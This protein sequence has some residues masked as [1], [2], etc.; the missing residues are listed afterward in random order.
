MD[1]V[2]FSYA[3]ALP[4]LA[5]VSLRLVPGWHGVVGANGAG[6]STLARLALREQA[7]NSGRVTYLPRELS[8]AIAEQDVEAVGAHSLRLA[9][10]PSPAA[11][12]WLGRLELNAGDIV[13]WA[14]LSPGERKRWQIAAVLSADAEILVLDEPTNHLDAHARRLVADALAKF[15]GIGLLISHDRE[16]L[17]QLTVSTIRVH[18]ARATSYPASYTGAKAL[19]EAEL[20]AATQARERIKQEREKLRRCLA[21]ARHKHDG[22]RNQASASGRMRNRHDRDA[23]SVGAGA[24]AARGDGKAGR[25][26]R[27]IRSKLQAPERALP[28][29][30]VDKTAQGRVF[31]RYEPSP[32]RRLISLQRSAIL[33]GSRLLLRDVNIWVDRSDRIQIAGPNGAGKTTLVR[34]LL[35][36]SAKLGSERCWYL[37]QVLAT[38]EVSAMMRELKGAPSDQAGKV[39]S[40]LATLGVDPARALGS[41]SL[42]PGEARKVSIALGL[43]KQVWLLVLDEPTNHLD[44]PSV[45]ALERALQDYPGA[46]IVVTHDSALAA[47]CTQTRWLLSDQRLVASSV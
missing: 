33:A 19:W 18:G 15:E 7:P 36:A 39:L 14:S 20:K 28:G 5:D 12:R 46:L 8:G 29:F 47:A 22:Q 27:A 1:R 37:P 35:A 38:D 6:K 16:L 11:R 13:R 30:V 26:I 44:L 3:D 4:I 17:D 45:E 41:S 40:V 9:R 32:N 25:Q 43:C 2:S 24:R 21:D 10:D 42:S 31:V 34:E 23:T